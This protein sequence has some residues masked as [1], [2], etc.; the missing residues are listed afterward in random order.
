LKKAL[1]TA[2]ATACLATTPLASH[3]AEPFKIGLIIPMTGPFAS[4]GKQVEA[5]A[6]LYMQQN[7]DKVDGRQIQL[8]VK[9]DGGIQP[10]TTKRLAQELVVQ[11]KVNVIAGFGLTP[12]AF[13]A[14]PI[15]T[16]S[17]TPMV[18]MAA[19][20][21]SIMQKSPYIVRTSMTLPQTTAPLADWA[22]K[23]PNS[24][25]KS[26]VTL[27]SDFG[28]G[29]D[30]E[31]V[32]TKR[33]TEGGGKI[34]G[35]LRIPQ[36]NPDFSPFLQRV[37]DLKPDAVFVFV[38]SG[39]GSTLMKQFAQRGL[40]AAGIKLIATG[41]VLDDDLLPSMGDEALG[42]ITSQH[43]STAHDS[44]EN[45]AYV[46]AFRKLTNNS[47]RPNFMSVGGYDGMHLIYA[48][49]KKAG[50]NATGDQL[51]AA[52]KGASWT[53]PRGPMSI[54]PQT[55]DVVQNVYIR[56]AEKV[57]GQIYNVE[58]DKIEHFKDPGV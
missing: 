35:N 38:P 22:A 53:S 29:H 42:I 10:E 54:D 32:F 50:P 7:G 27:V 33:F 58:F 20:T 3:A 43:Y 34:L 5:A 37:K 47:M 40:A 57:D 51:L 36:Q 31:K 11:E 44:P 14:A 28:P 41:D 49:L 23:N 24:H 19:G 15:A 55:R 8:I 39:Q 12:L 52:M 18:V 1:L 21:S 25:I 4:T 26:V 46:A 56:K 2:L 45:K 9:D 30:A 16:Q 17:K 6:R 48:A 13:A